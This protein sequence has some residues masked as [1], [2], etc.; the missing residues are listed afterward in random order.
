[1]IAEMHALWGPKAGN[2]ERDYE[3]A[4]S[5]DEGFGPAVAR[6]AVADGA[7]TAFESQAWMN[8]LV[9]RFVDPDGPPLEAVAFEPW[10]AKVQAEWAA[11]A[12]VAAPSAGG[13]SVGAAVPGSDEAIWAL[14]EEDRAQEATYGTFLGVE[15]GGLA[16]KGPGS[17]WRTLAIGDTV[18]FHVRAG[19]LVRHSPPLSSAEFAQ[20][21][22]LV[23][24]S[25]ERRAAD[26]AALLADAGGPLAEGDLILVA[27]DALAAWLL[28]LHEA[29]A[30]AWELAAGLDPA[31]FAELVGALRATGDLVNDDVTLLVVHLAAGPARNGD[32]QP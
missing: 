12:R 15:L 17:W 31:G 21:P 2:G 23:H 16:G 22:A 10:L 13:L 32:R 20:G 7:S 4:V 19:R 9:R 24:S 3:D 30:P 18:L 14:Y 25:P 8:M 1:V 6:A 11:E 28:G 5:F 27:T 29:G 26:C